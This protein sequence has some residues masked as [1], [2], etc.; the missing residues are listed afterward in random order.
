MEPQPVADTAAAIIDTPPPSDPVAELTRIDSPP[1]RVERSYRL[2]FVNSGL[3][4]FV[5]R[6]DAG[7][8]RVHVDSVAAQ[9]SSRVDLVVRADSVQLHL[10]PI[11]AAAGDVTVL[12]Y[13]QDSVR[14]IELAGP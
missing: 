1:S 13:P 8:E 2:L 4:G 10:A 5:V 9:D 14:R 6:A 11:G 3:R 7:A 12:R